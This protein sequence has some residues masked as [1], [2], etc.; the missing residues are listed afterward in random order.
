V[1]GILLFRQEALN[2]LTA[3]EELDSA[4]QLVTP[5]RWL[6]VAALVT[7]AVTVALWAIF[8]VTYHTVDGVG[9]I[10]NG[11]TGRIARVYVPAAGALTVREGQPVILRIAGSST[12]AHGRIVAIAESPEPATQ[13]AEFERNDPALAALHAGGQLVAVTVALP[14]VATGGPTLAGYAI[15]ATITGEAMRPIE[16]L[17]PTRRASGT[18]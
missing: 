6:A 3:P 12:P 8:G 15:H 5:S 11:E 9:V 2:K 1:S 18:H 17:F 16:T 7:L 13:L 4:V 14:P 10:Q